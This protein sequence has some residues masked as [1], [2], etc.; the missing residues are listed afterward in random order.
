A[1]RDTGIGMSKEQVDRLFREFTQGDMTMTRKYGGTGLGLVISRRFAELM[2]GKIEVES[3]LGAGST[4]TIVLPLSPAGAN[5]AS[6]IGDRSLGV[7]RVLLVCADAEMRHVLRRQL[8]QLTIVVDV[9]ERAEEAMDKLADGLPYALALLDWRLKGDG[10][11]Q[12]ASRIR[13]SK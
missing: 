6:R 7:V 2:G 3:E 4:F 12:L 11:V 13:E 1:V 9:A 8:E 5:D 10:T